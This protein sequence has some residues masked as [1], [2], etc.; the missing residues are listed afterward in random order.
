M[1]LGHMIWESVQSKQHS[2]CLPKRKKQSFQTTMKQSWA[3]FKYTACQKRATDFYWELG[4]QRHSSLAFIVLR[5]RVTRLVRRLKYR[6][7]VPKAAVCALSTLASLVSWISQIFP[8]PERCRTCERWSSHVAR[9]QPYV[10][11]ACYEA[12]GHLV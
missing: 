3:F 8:L 2:F 10:K 9:L 5:D 4:L 12:H 7:R 1:H 6:S 11:S